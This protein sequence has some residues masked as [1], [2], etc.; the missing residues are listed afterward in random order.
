MKRISDYKMKNEDTFIVG[1]VQP[2]STQYTFNIP[3]LPQ[4]PPTEDDIKEG[5]YFLGDLFGNILPVRDAFRY[6]GEL[7]HDNMSKKSLLKLKRKYFTKHPS[8]N[9]TNFDTVS[10]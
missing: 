1:T 7:L 9:S 2:L 10:G 3:N 4:I 6:V 5:F 8:S